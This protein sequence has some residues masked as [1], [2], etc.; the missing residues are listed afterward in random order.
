MARTIFFS[1]QSDLDNAQHRNFIERCIKQALKNLSHNDLAQIYMDYDRDTLG[2]YGSPDITEVIFD[3]IEKSILFVCDVSIVTGGNG[4][5]KSPNPNVLIELGF[6]AKQLG[7]ER[8]ICLFNQN[9][10]DLED[11]PF[12]L[13]QKRILAYNPDKSD[14]RNRVVAILEKNINS[15]F[16]KGML[17]NPLNDYMKGRIDRN[18]LEICKQLSNM[19]FGTV[20]MSEGLSHTNDFL[21]MD[22]KTIKERIEY[23]EFLGFIVFNSQNEMSLD[24][25]QILKEL[26]SSNYF[27]REWTYT[28]LEAID[29][30]R[31][32]NFFISRRN[33]NYPLEKIAKEECEKYVA[34]LGASINKDN[35]P[36]TYLVL[37]VAKADGER[38]VDTEGGRVINRTQYSIDRVNKQDPFMQCFKF[39]SESVEFAANLIVRWKSICTQWLDATD[40]EFILDPDYYHVY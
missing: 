37:E 11:L 8:V 30:I 23:S 39:K 32:Y 5:R 21:S 3:K 34:I 19:L 20:S 9:S 14:E 24:F 10:G 36:N 4:T 31:S 27:A 25:Q 16:V 40:G 6:A 17:F 7:W 13:R 38:Y 18:L 29:W 28:V 2:R 1:W 33:P 15:L 35:P 12:D 22:A 26:L